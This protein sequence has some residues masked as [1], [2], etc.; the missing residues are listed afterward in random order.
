M[1]AISWQPKALRQLRKI[2]PRASGQ[3][4]EAVT[5]ELV[6]LATARNLDF[7]HFCR[8]VG[9]GDEGTPTSPADRPAMLGFAKLTPTYERLSGKP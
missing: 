3:I 6:D 5:A 4:R 7:G 9:W 8:A 1:N 2:E